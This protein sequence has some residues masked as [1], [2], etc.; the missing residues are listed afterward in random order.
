L[1]YG[2]PLAVARRADPAEGAAELKRRLD[3]ASGEAERL[4]GSTV[5]DG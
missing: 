5:K 2:E 4:S 1:V 3:L